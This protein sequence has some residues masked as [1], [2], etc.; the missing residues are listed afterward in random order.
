VADDNQ[1]IRRWPLDSWQK[2]GYTAD[3]VANGWRPRSLHSLP[4]DV[5]LMDCQYAGNGRL[6][7]DPK[8][9]RARRMQNA[10]GQ[11]PSRILRHRFDGQCHAGGSGKVH[12][13]P[14]WRFP[15]ATGAQRD[16]HAALQRWEAGAPVA[17]VEAPSAGPEFGVP[18]ESGK[19]IPGPVT[20]K[21]PMGQGAIERVS[22]TGDP[23]SGARDRQ[24]YL[25]SDGLKRN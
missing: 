5:V 4:Y 19:I 15:S 23:E 6:R 22:S 25:D 10:S 21:P 24:P 1:V 7:G 9:S 14:A 12:R 11:P 18:V 16:L 3:A 20:E 8:D 13:R 2:L 17:G